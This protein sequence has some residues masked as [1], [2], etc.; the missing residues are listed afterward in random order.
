MR[1]ICNLLTVSIF[2]LI[3][4]FGSE[5]SSNRLDQ[6]PCMNFIPRL[7]KQIATWENWVT[8]IKKDSASNKNLIHELEMQYNIAMSE[9]VIFRKALSRAF[10]DI[11]AIQNIKINNQNIE[12]FTILA[13]SLANGSR[14]ISDGIPID[15]IS[16]AAMAERKHF[17]GAS[18]C[19]MM[20]RDRGSNCGDLFK[21][22]TRGSRKLV[23]ITKD[24]I[25][26]IDFKPFYKL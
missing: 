12:T 26:K 19:I 2:L 24:S 9:V 25:K 23:R 3:T 20:L 1:L 13:D 21:Q 4:S 11:S 17:I 10:P 6:I 15:I 22:D 8:K 14:S 18:D 7:Q 5:N 16:D